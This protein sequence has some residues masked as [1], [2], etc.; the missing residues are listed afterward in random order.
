MWGNFICVKL[1]M[2]VKHL[3]R[4]VKKVDG[5]VSFE[6]R[7]ETWAQTIY[8]GIGGLSNMVIIEWPYSWTWKRQTRLKYAEECIGGDKI[9]VRSENISR[10]FV[11]G[12]ARGVRTIERANWKMWQK[13]T[14][15]KSDLSFPCNNSIRQI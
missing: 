9:E 6:L 10:S 4:N 13:G 12:S 5:N 15:K 8:T 2:P 1:E 14:F 3:S 7:M 11:M